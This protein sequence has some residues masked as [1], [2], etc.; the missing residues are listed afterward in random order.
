MSGCVRGG[1][2]ACARKPGRHGRRPAGRQFSRDQGKRAGAEAC[3]DRNMFGLL[4]SRYSDAGYIPCVTVGG[5]SLIVTP[6]ISGA[7]WC[8]C[9]YL[10]RMPSHRLQRDASVSGKRLVGADHRTWRRYDGQ[11]QQH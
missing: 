10:V 9:R 5:A 3:V 4:V 7:M 11:S 2:A 6:R 1:S 8:Y